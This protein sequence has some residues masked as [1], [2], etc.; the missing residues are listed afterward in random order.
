GGIEIVDQNEFRNH[1]QRYLFSEDIRGP[2]CGEPGSKF[3]TSV[4]C[5]DRESVICL[6]RAGDV[7]AILQPLVA[8]CGCVA[9]DNVSQNAER[10]SIIHGG[11]QTSRLAADNNLRLWSNTGQGCNLGG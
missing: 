4:R 8:E 10:G 5:G 7:G 3:F 9:V 11:G 6:G 1:G 2:C